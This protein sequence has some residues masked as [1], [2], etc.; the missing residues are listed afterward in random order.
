MNW[1]RT[2]PQDVLFSLRT[3]RKNPVFVITTVITLG[4]GLGLNTAFFALMDTVLLK[5]LAVRDPDNLYHVNLWDQKGRW[6]LPKENDVLTIQN[7]VMQFSD[8]LLGTG[9]QTGLD[10]ETA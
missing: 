10:D 3:L 2:L 5:P 1:F 8:V 4:L 6:V 9:V 7:Q